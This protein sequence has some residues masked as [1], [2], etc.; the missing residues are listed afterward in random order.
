[1]AD[2]VTGDEWK[3]CVA[4][5]IR[6]KLISNE[7]RVNTPTA[8][9]YDF[10]H[11]LRDGVILCNLCNILCPES[12]PSKNFSQRPDNSQVSWAISYLLYSIHIKNGFQKCR[13]RNKIKRSIIK[14]RIFVEKIS[15]CSQR[16]RGEITFLSKK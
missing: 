12:I 16:Q 14:H 6:C 10:C 9:V 15:A 5:L 11:I 13:K 7:H 3:L 8:E 4:W 1:M 2:F